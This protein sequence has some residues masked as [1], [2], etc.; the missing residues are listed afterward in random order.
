MRAG[1]EEVCI[2]ETRPICRQPSW[3]GGGGDEKRVTSGI[4]DRGAGV[5]GEK[6]MDQLESASKDEN[7]GPH[8]VCVGQSTEFAMQERVGRPW[9]S[10]IVCH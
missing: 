9:W 8:D 4:G 2:R 7:D 5:A 6:G 10:P 1:R 3:G